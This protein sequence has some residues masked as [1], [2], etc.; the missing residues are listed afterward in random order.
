MTAA[1]IARA[2]RRLLDLRALPIGHVPSAD[3]D[4]GARA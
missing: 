4:N 3:N 1:E 2:M